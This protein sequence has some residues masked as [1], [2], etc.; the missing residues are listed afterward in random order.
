MAR[1]DTIRIAARGRLRAVTGILIGGSADDEFDVTPQ[2]DGAGRFTIPGSSLAGVLRHH[3]S[4]SIGAGQETIDH[5]FGTVRSEDVGSASRLIVHDLVITADSSGTTTRRDAVGIDRRSGTAADHIKF[6]QLVLDPGNE[7]DL[8]LHADFDESDSRHES[9]IALLDSLL[10]ELAAGRI[11]I[12]RGTTRSL[13]RVRLSGEQRV[14]S[15][16]NRN[17][18]IALS[19]IDRPIESDPTWTKIAESSGCASQNRLELRIEW[20]AETPVFSAESVQN[21]SVDVI[22][23]IAVVSTTKGAELKL[24]LPGTSVKGILRSEFEY[25]IRS[26]RGTDA[27]E[28]FGDQLQDPLIVGLFGSPKR[29]S[30][31]SIDDIRSRAVA[32]L[33]GPEAATR[34]RETWRSLVSNRGKDDESRLP[35]LRDR[36]KDLGPRATENLVPTAHVAINRWTSAPVDGALFSALEP[37]GLKWQPILVSIDLDRIGEPWSMEA[38]CAVLLIVIDRFTRGEVPLGFGAMR[39]YGSIG[40]KSVAIECAA[41]LPPPVKAALSVISKWSEGELLSMLDDD[42]RSTLAA[43][44]HRVIE[45]EVGD[46]A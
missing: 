15:L 25:V 23:R 29:K 31:L 36:L 27:P 12:G 2:I 24:V 28:E 8:S 11:R 21:G 3:A 42:S 4:N 37:H 33:E 34:L 14:F 43:A 18:V 6:D 39:G 30:A 9:A 5:L 38:F 32:E 1:H 35:D 46:I 17:D 10:G 16:T 13:G 19:Q 40:I 22:P 26:L 7:F 45:S 20:S 44:L 41:E